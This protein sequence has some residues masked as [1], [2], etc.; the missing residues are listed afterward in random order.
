S[1]AASLRKS[2]VISS[3]VASRNAASWPR[4]SA[5]SW[6]LRRT[7]SGRSIEEGG[8]VGHLLP[9]ERVLEPPQVGRIH[10]VAVGEGA[11]PGEEVGVAGEEPAA[12]H[13]LMAEEGVGAVEE[14]EV[15]GVAGEDLAE[16]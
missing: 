7:S 13:D 3:R 16:G 10:V 12:A 6:S 4:S 9:V 5:M 11:V 2:P 1:T 15:E 8:E 14:D